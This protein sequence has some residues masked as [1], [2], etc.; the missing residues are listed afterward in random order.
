MQKLDKYILALVV[1]GV[2]VT[3]HACKHTNV[4]VNFLISVLTLNKHNSM[5][6]QNRNLILNQKYRLV[7]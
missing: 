3:L 1:K 7:I 5:V 2:F 6:S 4:E